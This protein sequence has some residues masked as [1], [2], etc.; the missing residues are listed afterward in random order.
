MPRFFQNTGAVAGTF[1]AVGLIALVLLFVLVTAAIR[2]RRAKQF[3]R[4]IAEA[5]AEAATAP[6]PV[7]LDDDDDNYGPGYG[8]THNGYSN[9]PSGGYSDVSSHGTYGQPPMSHEG[10]PM[11]ERSGPGPGNPYDPNSMYGIPAAAGAAGIGVAR[12]RSV[13]DGGGYAAALNEGNSPYPAFATSHPQYDMYNVP[14]QQPMY[15]GPGSHEGHEGINMAAVGGAAVA[16]GMHQAPPFY[17]GQSSGSNLSRM[18]SDGSRSFGDGYIPSVATSTTAHNSN[19]QQ[20]ESYASHYQPGFKDTAHQPANHPHNLQPGTKVEDDAYGGYTDYPDAGRTPSPA[21]L[22]N[23]FA[24]KDDESG[25]ESEEDHGGRRVLKVS[26]LLEL[27]DHPYLSLNRSLITNGLAFLLFLTYRFFVSLLRLC[28][29]YDCTI[30]RLLPA[31]LCFCL[32]VRVLRMRCMSISFSI[33]TPT[34]IHLDQY[35]NNHK[36]R[37][38]AKDTELSLTPC[39]NQERI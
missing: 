32:V 10:Y 21:A 12:A 38:L 34:L 9:S 5:A 33:K 31:Y 23:P 4:E 16:A 22:P 28:H 25:D 11:S 14:P 30:P 15:R 39:Q 3:D 36:A 18:K 26:R 17:N 7:F 27:Q 29:R 2:R 37:L 13:R 19:V 6:V 35:H 20:G 8:Q 1:T 24:A